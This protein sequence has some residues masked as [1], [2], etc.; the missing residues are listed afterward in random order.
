ML[1]PFLVSMIGTSFSIR[2][3]APIGSDAVSNFMDSSLL[4][5]IELCG[6]DLDVAIVCRA[7]RQVDEPIGAMSRGDVHQRTATPNRI[8]SYD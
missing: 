4:Y 2:T 1:L 8:S 6:A 5:A 7:D 3:H